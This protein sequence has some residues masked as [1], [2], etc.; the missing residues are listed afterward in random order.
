MLEVQKNTDA[1]SCEILYVF[2][3]EL[4]KTVKEFMYLLVCLDLCLSND[5][6]EV[7]GWS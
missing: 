5:T 1:Q 4:L 3:E 6:K 7:T 2:L